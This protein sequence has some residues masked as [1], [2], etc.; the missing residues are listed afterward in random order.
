MKASKRQEK[1]VRRH[2]RLRQK[3]RGTAAR[4][5]MCVYVSNRHLYVQFVDDDASSTVASAST[6][7][8]GIELPK[9]KCTVAAA[10]QV[11]K[12]AA[13]AAIEKGIKQIVFDRG[14]FAFGG[15]LKALADAAREQ[16]LKF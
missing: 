13:A 5:R 16:G 11:G 8:A 4:P 7:G 3:V 2:L 15:R 6:R 14:G 1:R 9:G 12:L 10:K